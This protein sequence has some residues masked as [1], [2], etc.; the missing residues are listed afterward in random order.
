MTK[1]VCAGNS[2]QCSYKLIPNLTRRL[3]A[4][5]KAYNCHFSMFSQEFNK[6]N[7]MSCKFHVH[8]FLSLLDVMQ[9]QSH[10]QCI[11]IKT[12]VTPAGCEEWCES[13]I[14][15]NLSPPEAP[16]KRHSQNSSTHS[17]GLGR[18]LH[19][20]HLLKPKCKIMLHWEPRGKSFFKCREEYWV[21][22]QSP[23]EM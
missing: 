3:S 9:T 6:S 21:G 15:C 16:G 10:Q 8:V 1:Y 22:K 17:W 2:I 4:F 14:S 7:V 12:I 5:V 11:W 18:K 19:P 13:L 23:A 20:D